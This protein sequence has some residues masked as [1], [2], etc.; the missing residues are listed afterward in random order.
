VYGAGTVLAGGTSGLTTGT[1]SMGSNPM[2]VNASAADF[3]IQ[4]GG[5]GIDAGMDLAAV[6]VDADGVS[7]PQG[8]HTDQGAYE[9]VASTSAPVISG[10]FVSGVSTN[11]A[12]IYW[13]TD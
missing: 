12:F 13:S 6:T 11:S 10:V 8:A 5:P 4:S 1:N 9:R 3:H 7:R 2:F